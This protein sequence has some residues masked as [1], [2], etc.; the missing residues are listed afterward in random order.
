MQS[1]NYWEKGKIKEELMFSFGGE[2]EDINY[3]V[4]EISSICIDKKENIYLL[5]YKECCIKKYDKN[6]KFL[7]SFGRK[8]KGPGELLNPLLI[9]Y[10]PQNKN[11]Y[12]Y[13]GVKKSFNIFDSTGKYLSS[14]KVDYM[15]FNFEIDSLGNIFI[16]FRKPDQTDGHYQMYYQIDKYDSE[17]KYL[18]TIEKN[19]IDDFMAINIPNQLIIET[20]FLTGKLWTV[21]SSGKLF[22]LD[23]NKNI[24]SMRDG[25]G[26]VLKKISL[27]DLKIRVKN[28]EIERYYEEL[29]EFYSDEKLVKR[30]KSKIE[31]PKYKPSYNALMNDNNNNIILVSDEKQGDLRSYFIYDFDGVY[32]NKLQ[33]NDKLLNKKSVIIKDKLYQTKVVDEIFTEFYKF[34]LR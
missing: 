30:I 16:E 23:S 8:G 24:L 18:L 15:L 2:T 10:N 27:P 34:Q 1:N 20:P 33:G 6:G 25:N 29:K 17:L 31:I 22:I 12:V 13:D 11:L 26:K 19:Q 9:K 7:S 4:D 14:K 32:V 3:M 21:S 5:D 28:R